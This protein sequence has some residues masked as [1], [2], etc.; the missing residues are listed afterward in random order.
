[1]DV[2]LDKNIQKFNKRADNLFYELKKQI[3]IQI[4]RNRRHSFL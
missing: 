3:Q 4:N 2:G 1:M